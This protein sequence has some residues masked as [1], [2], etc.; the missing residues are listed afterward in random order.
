MKKLFI[1]IAFLLVIMGCHR[2]PSRSN[3][4]EAE[5]YTFSDS[6]FIEN[7]FEA[8]YS[9]YSINID[10]PVTNN[11]TLRHNIMLWMLNDGTEDYQAYF[12]ADKIRFFEEEGNEPTAEFVGNYILAEQTDRYVTYISSGYLYTGGAHPMPWYYGTSFSK[13]DGSIIGYDL[14]DDPDQLINLISENIREQYFEPNN[15]EEEEYLFD[16]DEPSQLP[17]NQP[18][19]ETDSGVFCYGPY[20]IAPYAAGMPLCKIAIEDMKPYLSERGKEL[21]NIQ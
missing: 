16:F 8:D 4:V 2:T 14:F 1:P 7:D 17:T 20:E 21:L 3:E 6:V 19:I 10:L 9:R 5:P 12:E 15:T 18:W 13:E 11:D